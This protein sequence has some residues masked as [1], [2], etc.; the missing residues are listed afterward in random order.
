[1]PGRMTLDKVMTTASTNKGL[2]IVLYGIE[3]VGKTTFAASAPNAIFIATEDGLR[4]Q[5]VPRFPSPK[6]WDEV[7][8]ATATLLR[9]QHEYRTL[10]L[11][12]LDWLEPLCWADV[13][14]KNGKDN[15][16]DF[17]YG[18]GYQYALQTWDRLISNLDQLVDRGMSIIS[19]AH[20]SIKR[21][22]DPQYGAFDRYQLKLHEKAGAKWKE[23]ADAV[24]FARHELSV[25]T[26]K[27]KRQRASS[28]GARVI[29]TTWNHAFDAKNRFD[30]PDLLP[31]SWDEF[32]EAVGLEKQPTVGELL[33]RIQQAAEKLP[34][35]DK[36]K[37]PK[38]IKW[39]G[40]DAA[41]LTSLLGKVKAKIEQEAA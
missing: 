30:L 1:M 8:E 29:Y 10:V 41:R 14:A 32:E 17:G 34:V 31:L 25:V 16:E 7:M 12:S 6:C 38:A 3:G 24:L 2:K 22:E 13:C 28:S 36:E 9:E 37:L 33:A 39:A 18:K 27:N 40:A 19:I 21:V 26:D 23:W 11:D 35:E 20:T 15:I 5:S 4:R